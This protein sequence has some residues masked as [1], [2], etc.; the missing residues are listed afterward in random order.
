MLGKK[1]F[2]PLSGLR[3]PFHRQEEEINQE[4]KESLSAL[5]KTSDVECVRDKAKKRS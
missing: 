2:S 5:R 4:A 1:A 3:I